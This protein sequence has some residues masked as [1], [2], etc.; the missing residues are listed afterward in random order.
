MPPKSTTQKIKSKPAEAGGKGKGRATKTKTTA[1]GEEDEADTPTKG[2]SDQKLPLPAWLKTFTDRGVDMRLA[3]T[4][5]GKLYTTMGSPAQLG[6]L[7]GPKLME[8]GITDKDQKRAITSAVRGL[9][10]SGKDDASPSASSSTAA[11]SKKRKWQQDDLVNPLIPG[12]P[13]LRKGRKAVEYDVSDFDFKEVHD[14]EEIRAQMVVTNRAPCMTAW[15]YIIAEKMG[16]DRLEALS[17]AST[18]TSVTS[19]K[20]ALALGNIYTPEQTRD[21]QLEMDELP[22]PSGSGKRGRFSDGGAGDSARVRD[23]EQ[24]GGHSQPWVSIMKRSPVIQRA[25]GTWRGLLKGMP[26]EPYRAHSYISKNFSQA[27]PHVIGALRILAQSYTTEELQEQG[28]GMYV[29]FR[30]DVAGWGDRAVLYCSN[31]ID[32]IP[33]EKRIDGEVVYEVAEG[34][35]KPDIISLDGTDDTPPR[36]TDMEKMTLVK[37]GQDGVKVED[38]VQAEREDAAEVE[39]MKRG[40]PATTSGDDE[41]GVEVEVKEEERDDVIDLDREDVFEGLHEAE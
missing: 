9:K 39:E 40:V 10:L 13:A 41:G 34:E 4:L 37:S 18:F 3:M 12:D 19:T 14:I 28:Y 30:P 16:F 25:D 8:V 23:G 6:K 7:N 1:A 32:M 36:I 26:V 27:T 35:R 22:Q 15:A 11:M 5:A 21:A 29:S 33:E 31:I 17:L 2:L 24:A 38:E 20:H